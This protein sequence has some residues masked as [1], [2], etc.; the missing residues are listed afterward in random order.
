M[1]N[2]FIVIQGSG[3]I[4]MTINI[5]DKCPDTMKSVLMLPHS[6][7]KDLGKV[8]KICM[9][10]FFFLFGLFC[11]EAYAQ[12]YYKTC[13][14]IERDNTVECALKT[15]KIKNRLFL[16]RSEKYLHIYR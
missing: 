8:S 11:F 9:I 7:H 12:L 3:E 4:Q 5:L 6:L 15:T 1:L 13:V 10:C 14:R 16:Y 2:I